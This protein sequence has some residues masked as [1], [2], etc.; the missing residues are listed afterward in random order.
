MAHSIFIV[1]DDTDLVYILKTALEIH[2]FKVITAA[3]GQIAMIMLKKIT[4]D[5]MI[6]DLTMPA[7]D[8]WRFT[9]KVR[10]DERFVKTPIIVCS[11]LLQEEKPAEAHESANVYIPKPYEIMDLIAKIK[12][13]LYV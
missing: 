4:P 11:G 2:G 12:A 6:V 1:D 5:L 10:Q 13:F 3:N 9:L 7:M 8:G